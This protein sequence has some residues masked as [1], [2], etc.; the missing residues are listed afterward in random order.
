MPGR[1]M[2]IAMDQAL[3]QSIIR[4][5][6]RGNSSPM[7][8]IL[9]ARK[10]GHAYRVGGRSAA[11]V[12][13]FRRVVAAAA[14]TVVILQTAACGFATTT[15]RVSDLAGAESALGR[16]VELVRGRI[17]SLDHPEFDHAGAQSAL[18]TPLTMLEEGRAGIYFLEP[19]DPNRIPVLFVPGIS[20]TPRDFRRMIQELDRSRFQAWVFQYPSGMRLE[21]IVRLLRQV[22]DD[23]QRQHRF[24][25]LFLTAHSVGGLIGRGYAHAARGE[26]EPAMVLVT[27][28]S[29]WEGHPW[30]AVG[31]QLMFAPVPS[32]VDLS[33]ASEFLVSLRRPIRRRGHR[34]SHYVFFGYQRDFS[35]LLSQSSDGVVPLASQ[36][37]VWLQD[38]AARYWGYDATHVGILSQEA[39]IERYNALLRCEADRLATTRSSPPCR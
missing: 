17:R 39:A 35:L 21:S 31:T 16:P 8:L 19:Y 7:R 25:T 9:R 3:T 34:F 11:S 27:F 33:P 24:D 13:R 28:S 20:G 29:P 15:G 38:Q 1:A 36:L 10:A 6:P 18:W 32:W 37:P 4:H 30:A 26:D 22:L 2:L 14:G 5:G 12:G 23:L